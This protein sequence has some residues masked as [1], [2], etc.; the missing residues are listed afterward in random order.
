MVA[1]NRLSQ[2]L[3]RNL[4]CMNSKLPIWRSHSGDIISCT[5][6]IKVMSENIT[7]IQQII[8]D[9]FEDAILMDIDEAQFK[10]YMHGL[11]TDLQNPYKGH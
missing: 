1:K 3:K 10:E 2:N 6:K 4:N 9:A 5:E 8:I 11:I 7:E